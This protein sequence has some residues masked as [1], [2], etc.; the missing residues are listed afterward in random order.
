[1]SIKARFYVES[2]T[3]IGYPGYQDQNPKVT[4]EKVVL[5]AVYSSDPANPNHSYSQATPQA[6]VELLISNANAWGFFKP[7]HSYDAAFT[8]TGGVS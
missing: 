6:R 5:Q 8:P 3:Q 7:G 2:V 1:M 4:S